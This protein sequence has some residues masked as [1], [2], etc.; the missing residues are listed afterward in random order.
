LVG[1]IPARST[2]TSDRIRQTVALLGRR[3]YALAPERLVELC[4]GGSI[5]LDEARWSVAASPELSLAEDMVV[6]RSAMDRVGDIRSRALGHCADT[7][8]GYSFVPIA[9]RGAIEL[10]Y[11]VDAAGVSVAVRP[12]RLAPGFTQLGTILNEQSAALDDF[13]DAI[14]TRG[15]PPFPNWVSVEGSWGR[16]RS[17]SLGV[18]WSAPVIA[19]AEL[20]AGRELIRPD[21]DSTGLDYLLP[22]NFAGP[23]YHVNVQAAR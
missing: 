16:L 18:E 3:A 22:A 9:S 11:T 19:G 23:P 7:A 8:H 21:F 6:D 12:I 4:L 2:A 14:Q 1:L 5:S 20:H 17:A 13:A 15:G 10:T